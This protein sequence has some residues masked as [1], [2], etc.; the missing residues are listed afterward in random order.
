ME[1]N[2]AYMDPRL[3]LA[4]LY[5]KMDKREKAAEVLEGVLTVDP[6]DVIAKEGLRKLKK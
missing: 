4:F 1:L 3:N 2:P 6:W 5:E